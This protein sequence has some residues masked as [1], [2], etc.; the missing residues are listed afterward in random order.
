MQVARVAAQLKAQ[1]PS[2]HSSPE[3][4][5][6]PQEPQFSCSLLRSAQV[7]PHS[8]MG[9][10]Q[11]SE[12]WP[13]LQNSPGPQAALQ[14]PQCKESRAV[15]THTAPQT[16][17]GSAQEKP[18]SGAPPELASGPPTMGSPVQPPEDTKTKIETR[19]SVVTARLTL[20]PKGSEVTMR[21]E[22]QERSLRANERSD[23]TPRRSMGGSPNS[24]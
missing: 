19:S 10:G 20:D 9:G 7:P 22:Y 3:A 6:L 14:S 4:H 11:E 15:S 16:C 5:A 12:H 23:R 8:T 13:E 2:E 18:A 17:R 21:L 1:P 24:A